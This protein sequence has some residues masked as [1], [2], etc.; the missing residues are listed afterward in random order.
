MT[1]LSIFDY[2]SLD[3][4]TAE[5]LRSKESNMRGIVGKAHTDLGKEL[6]ETQQRLA[7]SNQYNGLFESWY[8]HLGFKKQA[9]YNYINR[10][11]L[12]VQNL[13]DQT[14]IEELPVSLVYEI[15]KP[16]ANEELKQKVLYGEI[17]TLKEL[18]EVR[19]ALKQ[20]E[21]EKKRLKHLLEEEKDKPALIKEVIPKHIQDRIKEL[22]EKAGNLQKY[23]SEVQGYQKKKSDIENEM[24]Q[25]MEEARK[26]K[27]STNQKAQQAH[28]INTIAGS[29]RVVEQKK[30]E[31]Q[32]VLRRRIELDNYA[33]N[34]LRMKA[35]FLIELANE[36][37][38]SI[39]SKKTEV[40]II[41]Q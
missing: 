21:E 18:N 3:N 8:T 39:E 28:L 25:L 35:D 22:E 19:Q 23:K 13:D 7:G 16:S 12:L 36:I 24:A 26:I 14:L 32:Q 20:A 34:T 37:Y 38:D 31:I 33:K 2:T 10:Y 6:K 4:S 17:K 30:A 1:Q 15:S 9:V 40:Y 5:F 27:E 29:I 11:D 41:E